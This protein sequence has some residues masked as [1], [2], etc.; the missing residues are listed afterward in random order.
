MGSL[1]QISRGIGHALSDGRV[2][3]ILTITAGM[4]IWASVFYR[5]VEGW[6]WLDSFYFSVV[7]ISTVG[8][9]DISPQTAAGKI[10]TMGYLVVGLGVFVTAA[11]T[12]ADAI[13]TK[14][15]EDRTS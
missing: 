2:H 7:A 14:Y 1:R 9:G 3:G 4:I 12:F 5:F 10:F 11:T 13:L 6:S 15:K 8:F